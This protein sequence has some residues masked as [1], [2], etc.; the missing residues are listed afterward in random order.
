MGR[1]PDFDYENRGSSPRPPADAASSP[2]NPRFGIFDGMYPAPTGF[3][4]VEQ[5]EAF[6]CM[7][8]CLATI[9]GCA[10]EDAPVLCD[11]VTGEPVDRW[12]SV[13]DNW[14]Y[15]RGF[16]S[17]ERNRETRDGDDPMRCPWSLPCLWIGGVQSPRYDGAH[18]VVCRGRD[19]VWDPH[20]QREMGHHGWLDATYFL[21]IDPA[22][23]ALGDSPVRI[24][25]ALREFGTD[26]G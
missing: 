5:R 13:Y 10:Y 17:L 4:L 6:D 15:G 11:F 22:R 21:P 25:A 2:R 14:L 9:F 7:T 26:R 12:H 20:P 8:A 23:L 18:A 24:T 1:T 16:S 19:I 3:R